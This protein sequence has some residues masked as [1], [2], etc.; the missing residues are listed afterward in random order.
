VSILDSPIN[1]LS[2]KEKLYRKVY[3]RI[4]WLDNFER[5]SGGMPLPLTKDYIS[6]AIVLLEKIRE[7]RKGESRTAEEIKH[8]IFR[9]WAEGV[10]SKQSSDG[11]GKNE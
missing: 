8:D 4:E 11:G 9:D 1:T 3:E 10:L 5:Q 6:L 2:E 7:E